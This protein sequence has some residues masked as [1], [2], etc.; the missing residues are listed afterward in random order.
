MTG[1]PD[2]PP[3]EEQFPVVDPELICEALHVLKL[4]R[5]WSAGSTAA[6]VIVELS[7]LQVN[8][9]MMCARRRPHKL[10]GEAA[11]KREIESM[12]SADVSD[13]L[14]AMHERLHPWLHLIQM[15]RVRPSAERLRK[16]LRRSQ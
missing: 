2:E 14:R 8:Y 13:G 11:L 10:K 4:P 9:L 7:A 6:T 15:A 5:G 12:I 1:N 16:I 3:A